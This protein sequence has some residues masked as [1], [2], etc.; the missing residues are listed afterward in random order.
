[1]N[2]T[3]FYKNYDSSSDGKSLYLILIPSE[4]S[5]PCVFCVAK[6][7]GIF[8]KQKMKTIS[9]KTLRRAVVNKPLLNSKNQFF[10]TTINFVDDYRRISKLTR[11]RQEVKLN[12]SKNFSTPQI[13]ESIHLNLNTSNLLGIRILLCTYYFYSLSPIYFFL[14]QLN[15]SHFTEM[16]SVIVDL[17]EDLKKNL[18]KENGPKIYSK[19]LTLVDLLTATLPISI[20]QKKTILAGI[21]IIGRF[22]NFVKIFQTFKAFLKIYMHLQNM[23]INISPIPLIQ[24]T[25][26]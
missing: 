15:K 4:N 5:E 18:E 6:I 23:Q 11:N 26:N 24:K 12:N 9:F 13:K 19:V 16:W 2:L 3:K 10:Y 22:Q 21:D 7:V 25:Q 14:F 20:H 8:F 1:M 17:I